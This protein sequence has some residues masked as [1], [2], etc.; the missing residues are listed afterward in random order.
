[1]LL[2]PVSPASEGTQKAA[3]GLVV[4]GGTWG[5]CRVVLAELSVLDVSAADEGWAGGPVLYWNKEKW[6]ERN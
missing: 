3:W 6:Q 2:S 1:M 5:D 4:V